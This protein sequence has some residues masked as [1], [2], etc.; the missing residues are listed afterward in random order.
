MVADEETLSFGQMIQR[1]RKARGLSQKQL[2]SMIEKEEAGGPISPQYLNDIEFNR[3]SPTSDHLIRQFARALDLDEGVL[4]V[5]AGKIPDDLRRQV[6]D[7]EQAGAAFLAF[8]RS[9]SK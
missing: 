8:R 7:K 9:V 3:R 6:R 4:F 5:L 1:E 2:A